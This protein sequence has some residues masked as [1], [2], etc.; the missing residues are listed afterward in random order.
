M[1]EILQNIWF[2]FLLLIALVVLLG[3]IGYSLRGILIPLVFAFIVAYVFNPLVDYLQNRRIP[4][5]VT[6]ALL[7]LI[8]LGSIAGALVVIIPEFV[9]ETIQLAGLVQKNIPKIQQGIQE[10]FGKYG[11]NPLVESLDKYV[12]SA[13]D[14]LQQNMPQILRS[15]EAVFAG[16]VSYT[17]NIIGFIVNFVL[18]AVVSVYLLKDFHLVTARAEELIPVSHRATVLDVA[19]KING[20]LRGFFRGQ[21]LVGTILAV[22]YFIGLALVGVPYALLLALVGGYGQIIPYMGLILAMLPAMLLA[23]VKHG[24]FVHPLLAAMVYVFGQTM[25]GMIITPRVMADK[26]GL[27]PVVVILSILIFGKL[28][29]FLGILVAVPLTTVLLVLLQE[30]LVRYKDSRFYQPEMPD[31]G[32]D[33]D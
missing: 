28:L 8:I 12:R 32:S 7:L 13:L 19:A 3:W 33:R 5:P 6:I 2:R 30:A 22:I 20:K 14:A 17:F 9:R 4:R 24:D 15:A 23:L 1:K 25:E 18:F 26:V 21:L 11:G 27:H 31:A 10:L 16:A 29:G